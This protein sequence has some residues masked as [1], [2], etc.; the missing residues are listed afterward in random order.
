MSKKAIPLSLETLALIK[1]HL[2]ARNITQDEFAR[3]LQVTPKT[4]NN[5]LSGRTALNLV[6]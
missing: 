6:N 1:Q 2:A 3:Q 4:L 5:W